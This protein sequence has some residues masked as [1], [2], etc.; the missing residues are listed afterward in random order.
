MHQCM[1]VRFEHTKMTWGVGQGLAR[2]PLAPS[3][4]LGTEKS[5]TE[6]MCNISVQAQPAR[7]ASSPTPTRL[8]P[9]CAPSLW[10]SCLGQSCHPHSPHALLRGGVKPPPAVGG[11]EGG[12]LPGR[13]ARVGLQAVAPQGCPPAPPP[14]RLHL[15][16]R[17]Q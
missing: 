12:G 10:T 11:K 3:S 15:P 9:E 14:P 2:F 6:C 7:Q 13:E 4:L 16:Q 17:V 8:T 5:C 1:C